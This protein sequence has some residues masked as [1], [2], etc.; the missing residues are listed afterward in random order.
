MQSKLIGQIHDAL[1][2]DI[3]PEEE[4][5]VDHIIELYGT[6]KIRE[7]WPWIAVPLQ[8][9]KSVS[10]IS[11]NWAEMKEEKILGEIV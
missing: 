6:K 5:R 1:I 7:T 8:M 3:D 2:L 11:G 10:E 4:S 9:E